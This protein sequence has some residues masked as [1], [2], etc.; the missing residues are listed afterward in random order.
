MTHPL[1]RAADEIVDQLRAVR[2]E[3]ARLSAQLR[4]AEYALCLAQA[5]VERGL[6]RKVGSEKA[7]APTFEDRQRIFV[8]ALDADEE[9]RAR[10]KERNEIALRLEEAKIEVTYLREKLSAMLAAMRAGEET[11]E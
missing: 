9:Y 7:L 11:G 4:E 1:Y 6:I 5:R 3:V 8:L 2:H 10:L